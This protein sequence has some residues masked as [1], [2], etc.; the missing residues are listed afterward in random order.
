[1]VRIAPSVVIYLVA[2]EEATFDGTKPHT[3]EASVPDCLTFHRF[4]TRPP[5]WRD[6][7]GTGDLDA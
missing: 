6:I 3:V 4:E 1:V 5:L 2:G 7:L